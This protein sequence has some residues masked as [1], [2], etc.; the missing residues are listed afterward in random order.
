[1]SK[2]ILSNNEFNYFQENG[3]LIKEN[4]FKIQEINRI[5]NILE[6]DSNFDIF[7]NNEKKNNGNQNILVWNDPGSDIL[8]ITSRLEKVVGAIEQLMHD[9]VYHYHST[10]KSHQ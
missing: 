3:F 10:H 9:E 1:M 4:F 6:K 2:N 5:N 8:G 7:Y